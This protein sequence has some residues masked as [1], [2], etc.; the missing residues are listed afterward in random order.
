MATM[1]LSTLIGQRR[2]GQGRPLHWTDVAAY[3][4]LAFGIVLM[5]GPVLWLV[6]SSFKTQSALLEFPPSALPFA[7]VEVTVPGQPHE[8]GALRPLAIND[9]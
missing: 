1:R 2:N 9:F 6:M 5:F 3:V 4:Y 7:Q 8:N